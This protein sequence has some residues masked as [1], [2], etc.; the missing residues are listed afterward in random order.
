[1]LPEALR[2]R[3]VEVSGALLKQPKTIAGNME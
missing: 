3:R 1:V 2:P